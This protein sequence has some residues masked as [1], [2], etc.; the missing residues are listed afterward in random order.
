MTVAVSTPGAD[1]S[2]AISSTELSAEL[3]GHG[4]SSPPLAL[5]TVNLRAKRSQPRTP[6]KGLAKNNFL[7]PRWELFGRRSAPKW[8]P[9]RWAKNEFFQ[10]FRRERPVGP[11]WTLIHTQAPSAFSRPTAS[12]LV[13][14][15]HGGLELNRPLQAPSVEARIAPDL[16]PFVLRDGSRAGRPAASSEEARSRLDPIDVYASA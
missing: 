15:R 7:S 3:R 16:D 6:L 2:Y 8:Y 13:L 14:L 12:G 1:R 11:L 9:P 10:V 5:L 4:V